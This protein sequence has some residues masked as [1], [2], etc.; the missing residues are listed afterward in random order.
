MGPGTIYRGAL[1]ARLH[2]VLV[3]NRRFSPAGFG[4]RGLDPEEVR[5]FLHR[6]ALE[7]TTLHHEV[8]RLVEENARIKQALRDWQTVQ[9][10]RRRS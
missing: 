10:R 4:R 5:R 9:A 3:R 2:P 7:L 1:P 6:V 8:D